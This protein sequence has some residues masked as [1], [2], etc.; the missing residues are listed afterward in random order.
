M[1]K[2]LQFGRN[3]GLLRFSG[4]CGRALLAKPVIASPSTP[5]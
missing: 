1:P 3:R 4:A 2:L 5:P